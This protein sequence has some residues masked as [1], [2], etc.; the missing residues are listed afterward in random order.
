MMSLISAGTNPSIN[1]YWFF[2]LPM[3]FMFEYK[4]KC[5]D[6]IFIDNNKFIEYNERRKIIE[7]RILQGGN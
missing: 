2:L 3:C 4:I 7:S 5:S 6:L 1:E